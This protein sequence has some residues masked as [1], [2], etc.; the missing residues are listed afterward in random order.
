[1]VSFWFYDSC[2]TWNW[3]EKARQV[4]AFYATEREEQDELLS[5]YLCWCARAR[6]KV[7]FEWKSW[8][9]L[10]CSRSR[11]SFALKAQI[12]CA[13]LAKPVNQELSVFS[14]VV[15]CSLTYQPVGALPLPLHRL[16]CFQL[17]LFGSYVQASDLLKVGAML[18]LWVKYRST[19][20]ILISFLINFLYILLLNCIF[21]SL[22]ALVL[23][24]FSSTE[25]EV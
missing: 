5:F 25:A 24:T 8:S 22:D 20:Q 11:F 3:T 23:D 9:R 10:E 18:F 7:S 13:G 14:Y 17:W 12:C 1:M 4:E 19:S 6:H 21:E 15:L 16:F 2:K